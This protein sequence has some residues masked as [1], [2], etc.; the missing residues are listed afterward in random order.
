MEATLKALYT[1]EELVTFLDVLS[2]LESEDCEM[3]V[4]G[5]RNHIVNILNRE[6]E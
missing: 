3:T 5:M 2:D 6:E 4:E 1:S